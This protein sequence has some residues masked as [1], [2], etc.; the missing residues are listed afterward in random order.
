M[1]RGRRHVFGSAIRVAS[2]GASERTGIAATRGAAHWPAG[3]SRDPR[4]HARILC[5]PAARGLRS[6]RRAESA[7]PGV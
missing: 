2:L 6:R 4:M 5:V 7:P 3:E 1:R